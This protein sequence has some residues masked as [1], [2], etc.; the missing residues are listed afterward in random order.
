MW[1]EMLT[2]LK[3]LGISPK[4]AQ[5]EGLI[6]HREYLALDAWTV[7]L[8]TVPDYSDA[9]E[10]AKL[11]KRL[12]RKLG[13]LWKP[14]DPQYVYEFGQYDPEDAKKLLRR[15]ADVML[16]DSRITKAEHTVIVDWV[17]Q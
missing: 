12:E 8:E 13:L 17:C 1:E 6:T 4:M 11:S 15:L 7:H 10:V 2:A 5:R 14:D 3:E 9:C 16:A